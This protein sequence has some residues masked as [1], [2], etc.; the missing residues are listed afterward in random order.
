MTCTLD[1]FQPQKMKTKIWEVFDDGYYTVWSE[2]I[3]TLQK[4]DI[5]YLTTSIFGYDCIYGC[6]MNGIRTCARVKVRIL[7]EDLSQYQ[8]DLCR[9]GGCYGY[10]AAEVLEVLEVE[11]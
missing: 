9:D 8:S 4:G 2:K 6:F 7:S 11:S 10:A 1:D 3:N 5:I